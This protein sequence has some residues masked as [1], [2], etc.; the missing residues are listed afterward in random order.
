MS[1]AATTQSRRLQQLR[2]II[3]DV[4]ELEPGELTDTGVFGDD[5]G[6]DSLMA[7]DIIAR[8]ERDM[9]VQVPSEALPHMTN[10][11][12]VLGLVTRYA[13]ENPDA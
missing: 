1:Q 10:L 11:N 9:G 3:T 7:I 2:D 6:A 8:I 5:Y 12:A 13:E 4:L